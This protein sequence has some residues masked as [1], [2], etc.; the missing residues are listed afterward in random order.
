MFGV[1]FP[2][3]SAAEVVA[4]WQRW[5]PAADRRL[6]S[7][8]KLLAGS[9]HPSGPSVTVSG[10]WTGPRTGAD[11]AVDGF[12]RETG[13][14]PLAHTAIATTYAD[15]MRRY[16]G[17]GARASEAATSSIGSRPL[18]AGG[19]RTMLDQVVQASAVPGLVEGGVALDALG[20][21]V[22]DLDPGG[23]AFP[24]RSALW[25]AQYTATFT[26]GLDPAPF[27]ASVRG[28]RA[29]MRPAWGDAA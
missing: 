16:A 23:T 5:A 15:A 7:S 11:A 26:D 19:I 10:T 28:F 3:S 6:W 21:A 12:I 4:A 14:R 27:D 25:T 8:L 13:A 1:T 22:G 2:W 24:W 9:R 17:N 29:A 18:A 20:G